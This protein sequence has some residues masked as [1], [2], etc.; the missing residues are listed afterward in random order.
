MTSTQGKKKIAILGKP[1]N[2]LITPNNYIL[3]LIPSPLFYINIL[4]S[5]ISVNI[6]SAGQH[7]HEKFHM[8][9]IKS[10]NK[11]IWRVEV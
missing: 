5:K 9:H 10:L 11:S 2:D 7:L 1:A 4:D 6:F 3:D 8:I